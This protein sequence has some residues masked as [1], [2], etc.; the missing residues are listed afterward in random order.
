M[1][2]RLFSS[3]D[4]FDEKA[5]RSLLAAMREAGRWIPASLEASK[6]FA[7]AAGVST[8]TTLKLPS[9]WPHAAHA[10]KV[11]VFFSDAIVFFVADVNDL[12]RATKGIS[13]LFSGGNRR[14]PHWVSMRGTIIGAIGVTGSVQEKR[15]KEFAA[16][17]GSV[18]TVSDLGGQPIEQIFNWR[19]W[20]NAH[21]ILL[22]VPAHKQ[23]DDIIGSFKEAFLEPGNTAAAE[24]LAN[25]ELRKVIQRISKKPQGL[26]R[27][28]RIDES[29][30]KILQECERDGLISVDYVVRCRDKGE[31]LARFSDSKAFDDGRTS[32]AVCRY[33]DRS[34]SQEATYEAFVLTDMAR[35]LIRSSHWMT[36]CVTK[37]LVDLGV[38]IDSVIWEA[39]GA[40]EEIDILFGHHGYLWAVELKDSEF[41]ENH[42]R[43]FAYRIKLYDADAGLAVSTS[44]ITPEADRVLRNSTSRRGVITSGERSVTSVELRNFNEEVAATFDKIGSS[45]AAEMLEA[46]GVATGFDVPGVFRRMHPNEALSFRGMLDQARFLVR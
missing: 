10:P 15:I 28:S 3:I 16:A 32:G 11:E 43:R 4:S 17:V 20:P 22:G 36:I 41:N 39:S 46:L 31:I 44:Q 13:W 35:L 27:R 42:A 8:D 14:A 45:V 18:H 12:A 37:R 6:K 40:G 33:C 38:H 23:R 1:E 25:R 5:F 9:F 7:E 2:L 24:I 26:S 21:G 19:S 34:W 29:T 30:L